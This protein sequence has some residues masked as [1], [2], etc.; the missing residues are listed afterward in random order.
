MGKRFEWDVSVGVVGL[1]VR[2][3]NILAAI[4][5]AKEEVVKDG[6]GVESIW[7]IEVIDG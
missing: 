3:D 2:A 1:K 5:K 4:I 7:K 6:I